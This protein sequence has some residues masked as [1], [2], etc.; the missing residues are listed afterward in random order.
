[1]GYIT[2]LDLGISCGF[3]SQMGQY[4]S[5]FAI[6]KQSNNIPILVQET[7]TNS[8]FGLLIS[9]PF[10]IKP[11]IMTANDLK[12]ESFHKIKPQLPKG[13]LI[14]EIDSSLYTLPSDKNYIIHEDIGFWEYHAPFKQDILNLFVFEDDIQNRCRE[15]LNTHNPNNDITVSIGF[16][17]EDGGGASLVLSADYY[18]AAIDTIQKTFPNKTIKFFVFSGAPFDYNNGWDWIQNNVKIENA[19]YVQNMDK[20]SQMCLMTMC[21]HN[22]IANSS[23][24]WWGGYLNTNKDK[25]VICPFNYLKDPR[26]DYINGRYYPKEWLSLKID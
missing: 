15:Y 14:G 19:V 2:K 20:F 16:R 24:S 25:K 9:E 22:I 1:M 11:K 7:F 21:N 13:I 4:A 17:R 5:M 26:F 3:G 10:K 23:F 8:P 6:A 12:N 18:S